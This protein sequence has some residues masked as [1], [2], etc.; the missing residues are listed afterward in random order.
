MV[1]IGSIGGGAAGLT[2]YRWRLAWPLALIT[3]AVSATMVL[4]PGLGVALASGWLCVSPRRALGVGRA[5]QLLVIVGIPTLATPVG[6]L[7]LP[8]RRAACVVGRFLCW[9][10]LAPDGAEYQLLVWNAQHTEFAAAL[11]RSLLLG[12]TPEP[13]G[14]KHGVN[15]YR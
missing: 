12:S 9:S 15:G 10:S 6:C 5:G 14:G 13:R 1:L 8:P 7:G 3:A 4:C 2:L 11:R